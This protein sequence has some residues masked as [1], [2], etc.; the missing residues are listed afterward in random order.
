MN[1]KSKTNGGGSFSYM[2]NDSGILGSKWGVFLV[3]WKAGKMRDTQNLFYRYAYY[4][5]FAGFVN[6]GNHVYVSY[7]ITLNVGSPSYCKFIKSPSD[8]TEVTVNFAKIGTTDTNGS[9]NYYSSS[10]SYYLKKVYIQSSSFSILVDGETH[11]ISTSYFSRDYDN[12][13]PNE[14]PLYD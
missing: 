9:F 1:P 3:E 10:R 12:Y 14:P 13:D 7:P 4:T 5:K 11:F 8:G 2:T 6:I